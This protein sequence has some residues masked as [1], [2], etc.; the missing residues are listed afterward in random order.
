M[1]RISGVAV[2]F[3]LLVIGAM[4]FTGRIE[5]HFAVMSRSS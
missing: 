1:H 5:R 4:L 2:F 3:W